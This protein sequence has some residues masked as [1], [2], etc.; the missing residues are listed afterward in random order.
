MELFPH[1]RADPVP[2]RFTTA[3]TVCARI[4]RL[5]PSLRYPF[6]KG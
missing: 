3:P 4:W 6:D 1:T 5:A 2:A